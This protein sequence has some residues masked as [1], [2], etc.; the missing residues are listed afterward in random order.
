[1]TRRI[2]ILLGVPVVLAVL[3]AVPLVL[4][5]GEYQLLCAAVAV[6][7]VVPPGLVTLVL[8]E[9]LSRASLFGPLLALAIGTAIRLLVGFGGGAAVFLLSEPTFHDEP[10]SYFGWLLGVYLVTLA[11]ETAL[12]AR[13]A[14]RTPGQPGA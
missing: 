12:L 4:V 13:P 6:G 10:L 2:A 14:P 5:R 7:L 1:V 8:A 11:T 3:V 9:K